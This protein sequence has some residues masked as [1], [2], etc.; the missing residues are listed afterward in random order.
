MS[1]RVVWSDT[2]RER[3]RV[4]RRGRGDEAAG[5]SASAGPGLCCEERGSRTATRERAGRGGGGR[6][7]TG[8]GN[9]P[10]RIRPSFEDRSRVVVVCAMRMLV[11]FS[12][13]ALRSESTTEEFEGDGRRCCVWLPRCGSR[14]LLRLASH[15]VPAGSGELAGAGA[16]V[17]ARAR[18]GL[19]L[20]SE[21]GGGGNWG[22]DAE[23]ERRVGAA[24]YTGRVEAVAVAVTTGVEWG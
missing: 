17:W 24:C 16:L 6:G 7:G 3:I 1:G 23:V 8:A 4:G 19:G 21:R 22:G 9:A 20:G 15:P 2:R 14:H 5:G 10:A 13:C 12:R 18:L 11:L